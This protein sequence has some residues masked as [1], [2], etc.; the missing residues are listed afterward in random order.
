MKAESTIKDVAKSTAPTFSN[1]VADSEQAMSIKYNNLVYDLKRQGAEVIVLSLGEAFFDIPLFPMDD[2]P[3]PQIY[4]YTHSRGIPELR[5]KICEY[6]QTYH[7]VSVDPE[8]EIIVTAGSKAAIHFSMMSVLNPG[9]EVILH[10]PTWVSYPE[11]IKLCYAKPVLMPYTC[12]VDDYEKYLTDRSKLIVINNPHNPRGQVFS[13][14]ELRY[15]VDLAKANGLYILADEAYSDFLVDERFYSLGL[16]DRDK[17]NTIICNSISKNFGISG[18]RLGYCITNEGLTDQVLKVNQHL[19][20]CPAAILQY[21]IAKHYDKIVEIT[22]PQIAEVV[23]KRKQVAELMDQLSLRYLP[24]SA[25]FYFFVSIAP[26]KL[27]SEEFCT[28]LLMEDHVSV[29]PGRGYGESCDGFV[30]L[31]VGTESLA[32]INDGLLKLKKLIDATAAVAP[33]NINPV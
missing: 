16:F 4:H 20:T 32:D 31:S 26:S 30:R 13:E 18:W 29:V 23:K 2:L 3:F 21:Y 11:Q 7:G 24:G 5:E 8:K 25:T 33:W 9:D 27:T 10:E 14:R 19:I 22:Y 12:A 1:V 28:R 6:Y 17:G 15:L